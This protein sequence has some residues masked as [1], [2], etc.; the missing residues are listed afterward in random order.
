MITETNEMG[1]PEV[2]HYQR[3]VIEGAVI[4]TYEQRDPGSAVWRPVRLV[5]LTE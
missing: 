1:V 4:V 2:R 5:C 3:R